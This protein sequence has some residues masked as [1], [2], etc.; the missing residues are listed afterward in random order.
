MK[1]QE[2]T[3]LGTIIYIVAYVAM[4]LKAYID[5]STLLNFDKI[6]SLCVIAFLGCMMC[7][8]CMQRYRIWS[9][10]LMGGMLLISVF[11]SV[12]T[13]YYSMFYAM[14]F[15]FCLQ[16]VDLDEVLRVS[17]RLKTV[18]IVFHVVAYGIINIVAPQMITY[19]YRVDG[20]P[21]HNF[22]LGHA[23]N[24]AGYVLWTGLE[25]LYVHRKHIT[26]KKIV[27]VWLLNFVT[28]LFTDSRTALMLATLALFMIWFSQ[29]NIR[30]YDGF[31]TFFS[32]YGFMIFTVIFCGIVTVRKYL[33]GGLL[34]FYNTL[35][36]MLSNR[37]M[38]GSYTIENYGISIAGRTLSFPPKVY[39]DG[40]WIDGIIFDNFYLWLYLLYGSVYLIVLSIVFL[41]QTPKMSNIEKVLLIITFTYALS[42]K[43]VIEAAVCFPLLLIGKLIYTPKRNEVTKHGKVF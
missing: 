35:D 28:Y 43:Y 26:M 10:L 38:Y 15:V 16:N 8:L 39:W 12:T 22:M 33:S 17:Y 40:H 7:K 6:A 23:N 1:K 30:W 4:I 34:E 29:K 32:K 13:S 5:A 19:S 20:I 36:E 18:L 2:Y 24:F 14:L 42:E 31:L 27:V 37:L 11:T 3:D 41:K 21:R 9:I 25:Y